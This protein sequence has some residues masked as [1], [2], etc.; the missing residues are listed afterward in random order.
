MYRGTRRRPSTGRVL[1]QRPPSE[2]A[3]FRKALVDEFGAKTKTTQDI[4]T[5]DDMKRVI[6]AFPEFRAMGGAESQPP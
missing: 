3:S 2:Q 4:Q 5:I 1:S 6:S